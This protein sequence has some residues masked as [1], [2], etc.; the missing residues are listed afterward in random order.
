MK[1]THLRGLLVLLVIIGQIAS[2][3]FV[4][5]GTHQ[6]TREQFTA[7]ADSTLNDFAK[8][9]ADQT[10]RYLTPAVDAVTVAQRL[11][12]HDVISPNDDAELERYF[13]AKLESVVS[14]NGLYLGRPDGSFLF[15]N[16]EQDGLRTKR[17]SLADD[18]RSVHFK[19]YSDVAPPRS[20][21]DNDD[22]Y[23]PRNRPWYVGVTETES[24][25]WTEPYM[26]FSS[27][28][29]GI[30]AS[31]SVLSD[32][33]ERI[34][35]I[36]VDVDIS[37]LSTF[38]ELS[39]DESPG[40][41]IIIDSNQHVIAY[42]SG[43]Y[44]KSIEDLEDP[45]LLEDVADAPL[46]ALFAEHEEPSDTSIEETSPISHVVT[47]NVAHMGLSRGFTINGSNTNWMLLAQIPEVEYTGEI[48]RLLKSNLWFLIGTVL[49]PGIVLAAVIMRLTAPLERYY[50]EASVDQLTGALTR[51][52]FYRRLEKITR[53][54]RRSDRDN[55]IVVVVLD[56][57]GFK[58]VNDEFDH[59]VG[60]VVLSEIAKRLRQR[61]R[62]G[63]LVGRLGGDEFV[64]ALRIPKGVDY[65]NIVESVRCRAVE[66]KIIS[67]RGS[68]SLGLTAG[69]ACWRE[70][71]S[72]DDVVNRADKALIRGKKSIKN[73][74][75]HESEADES[76][77]DTVLRI[78]R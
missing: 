38:I 14:L 23:D 62:H 30:S 36:G 10:Q 29:P 47:E 76:N 65:M 43:A 44:L 78:I 20:W 39:D 58:A 75:Y 15:V 17:I 77:N 46:I 55:Q 50:N 6:Q 54:V 24:L 26:F 2:I 11:V 19:Q 37:D 45:P 33:G 48:S 60:D 63:E 51:T 27:G 74:C 28:K 67:P 73:R 71:E 32:D 57:D 13:L 3:C 34:G 49:L 1:P 72:V 22:N 53:S 42:S 5:I 16:R 69:V 35:V 40:S 4:L 61:I 21:I 66:D 18:V 59:S 7:N 25:V 31:I 8:R 52:E 41:A 70:G 12:N 68:H 9:V 56:L 64:L